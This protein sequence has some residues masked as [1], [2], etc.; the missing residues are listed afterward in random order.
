MNKPSQVQLQPQ[1][2]GA[3]NI[4]REVVAMG[5]AVTSAIAQG[6]QG[7]TAVTPN[8][9]APPPLLLECLRGSS[10]TPRRARVWG[11]AQLV[12]SCRDYLSHPLVCFTFFSP[13]PGRKT[14]SSNQ[15]NFVFT[16]QILKHQEYSQ[17]PPSCPES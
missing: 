15:H 1:L 9:P 6:V 8:L 12:S 11:P 14:I 7:V 10:R 3:T 4:V 17:I 2:G 5:F 16:N 13:S